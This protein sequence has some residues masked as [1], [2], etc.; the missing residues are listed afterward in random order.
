MRAWRRGQTLA[1]TRVGTGAR[2]RQW[3]SRGDGREIWW[4]TRLKSGTRARK[5]WPLAYACLEILRSKASRA[6]L[7]DSV[8]SRVGCW[9][10]AGEGRSVRAVVS[11]R[12]R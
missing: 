6:W 8:V 1:E 3:R 12:D 9:E 10:G 2:R 4:R 11:L 7:A 5:M